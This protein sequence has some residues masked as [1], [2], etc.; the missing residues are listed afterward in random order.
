MD[1]MKKTLFLWVTICF[2]LLSETAFAAPEWRAKSLLYQYDFQEEQGYLA[3]SGDWGIR[4]MEKPDAEAVTMEDSRFVVVSGEWSETG[5]GIFQESEEAAV[6]KAVWKEQ[7]KNPVLSAEITPQSEEACVFLYFSMLS[8]SDYAAV[9]L[10]RSGSRLT[11]GGAEYPGGGA[12]KKDEKTTLRVEI[13]EDTAAV[14]QDGALILYQSGLPLSA[15]WVGFG[16][17]ATKMQLQNAQ[18]SEQNPVGNGKKLVQDGTEEAFVTFP[19]MTGENFLFQ[20]RMGADNFSKGEIGISIRTQENQDGYRIRLDG[21]RILAYRREN[22]QDTLLKKSVCPALSDRLYMLTV[23]ADRNNYFVEVNRQ[24]ALEFSDD[25][26]SIG[27]IGCFSGGTKLYVESASQWRLAEVTVP[28]YSEGNTTYYIDGI[29]GDD[30]KD[31]KT[32]ETAWKTLDKLAFC[33]FSEGD[34]ILFRR[35]CTYEGT[36]NLSNAEHVS[37]SAWGE[38]EN[39]VISGCRYAA[40]ISDSSAVTLKF[41]TLKI[42]HAGTKGNPKSGVGAAVSLKN[43]DMVQLLDCMLIGS[44]AEKNTLPVLDAQG[45]VWCR[46]TTCQDFGDNTLPGADVPEEVQTHWAYPVMRKLVTDG[47]LQEYRPDDPITRAEFAV[48][49][50]KYIPLREDEYHWIFPDVGADFWGASA[51][52]TLYNYRMISEEMLQDGMVLPDQPVM[53]AEAAAMLSGMAEEKTEE[54]PEFSDLSEAPEWTREKI[55]KACRTGLFTGRDE[56]TFAPNET[57]TRAETAA[58]LSKL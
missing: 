20:A 55:L 40:E 25:T 29:S 43:T 37:V 51:L 56:H 44:G 9:E 6:L 46:N 2:F 15:G 28:V 47:I 5:E 35:G 48:L 53:R 3:N 57:L 41:L 42:R 8:G 12:L 21:E 1:E 4:E 32:P 14:Y 18:V 33:R 38:G 54:N 34:Q 58:L 26:F 24:N 52:Q 39:P 23:T 19:E 27:A 10:N 30:H 16:S 36:L 50:T 7:Y 45:S 11:A 13:F 49:L 31:G 22:G 17:W